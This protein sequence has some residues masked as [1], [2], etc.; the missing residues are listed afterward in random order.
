VDM[1]EALRHV[2]EQLRS[3]D[4]DV[5]FPGWEATPTG[6][7]D[8]CQAISGTEETRVPAASVARLI[9][10]VADMLE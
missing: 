6:I 8:A 5:L 10:Y 1:A 4:G 3:S 9:Q 2:A 7:V